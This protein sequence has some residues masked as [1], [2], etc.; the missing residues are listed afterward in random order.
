MKTNLLEITFINKKA[1]TV[2]GYLKGNVIVFQFE[3]CGDFRFKILNANLDANYLDRLFQEP[4]F[5]VEG[6]EIQATETCIQVM[7]K[8]LRKRNEDMDAIIADRDNVE[9]FFITRGSEGFHTLNAM[10]SGHVVE[11]ILALTKRDPNMKTA[12]EDALLRDVMENMAH[13]MG[14]L[15]E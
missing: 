7:E 12:L 15:G 1:Q 11:C 9:M 13:M 6:R 5:E 4:Y 2:H 14:P 8:I 3:A 10:P